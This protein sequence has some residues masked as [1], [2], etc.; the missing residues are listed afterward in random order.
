MIMN[1]F[2]SFGIRGEEFERGAN[3]IQDTCN[4]AKELGL[5][6]IKGDNSNIGWKDWIIA[7]SWQRYSPS[8]FIKCQTYKSPY[9]MSLI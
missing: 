9:P 4:R 3:N 5:C 1:V 7:E 2:C 6:K 8:S